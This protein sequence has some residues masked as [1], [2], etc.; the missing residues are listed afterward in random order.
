VVVSAYRSCSQQTRLG[1][2]TYH[3]QQYQLL[4]SETNTQPDPRLQFLDDLI[5]QIRHWRHQ[6]KAVLV[7]MDSND[8]VTCINPK[9]GIG[10]L[11][12]ETDLINLHHFKYPHKPRPPTYTRGC[13]TLDFCIGSPEFMNSL[14]EAAILPFGLP[15]HLTGDHQALILDFDSKILFGNAAPPLYITQRCGVYS[16]TIP[17][18]TKFSQLVGE[19]CGEANLNNR[20]RDIEALETL[21]ESDH[22]I[23]DAIDT[24]LTQILVSADIKCRPHHIYP[25]S[26]DLH[27]A[28]LDHRYWSVSLTEKRTKCSHTHALDAIKSK[29]SPHFLPLSPPDTISTRLRR[30]RHQL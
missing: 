13:L 6:Q 12:S 11:L 25:W 2:G 10:W 16:N 29:L 14:V 30:A 27:N 23:L 21:T 22:A 19:G 18:V 3:N 8:D 28:Y 15:T 9:K 5:E 7:C 24:D 17:L 4:L 1:S 26:P 20:I